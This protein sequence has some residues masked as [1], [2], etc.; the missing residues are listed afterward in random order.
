[1]GMGGDFSSSS[2]RFVYG[3]LE[4]FHSHLRLVRRGAG[5]EDATRRNDFDYRGP[6]GDLRAHGRTDL[7]CSFHLLTDKS[8][9]AADHANRQ[10]VSAATRLRRKPQL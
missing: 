10:A 5:R 1:M 6:G 2:L 7:L 4:F 9:V 3:G 8:S